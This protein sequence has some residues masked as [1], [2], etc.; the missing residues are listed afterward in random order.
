M[1]TTRAESQHPQYGRRRS[2]TTQSIVKN[3]PVSPIEIGD[4]K[5]LSLW[6][7]DTKDAVLSFNHTWWPGVAEGDLLRVTSSA[8]DGKSGFLFIA[9]KEDC[10]LR[11]QLQVRTTITA[12]E[13][14]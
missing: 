14:L 4:F 2:N 13:T 8:S 3:P 5:V 12:F 6:V 1:S 10:N 9:A 11:P 7:D